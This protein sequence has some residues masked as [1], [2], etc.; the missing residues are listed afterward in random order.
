MKPHAIRDEGIRRVAQAHATAAPR[1]AANWPRLSTVS[2]TQVPSGFNGHRGREQ[3]DSENNADCS[4]PELPEM[5]RRKS[6][7]KSFH[8]VLFRLT[9]T[10]SEGGQAQIELLVICSLKCLAF[11]QGER[12][13]F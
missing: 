10:S 3:C 1:G 7:A 6:G 5:S 4:N 9:C 12:C 11:A 2:V 13:N 8:P